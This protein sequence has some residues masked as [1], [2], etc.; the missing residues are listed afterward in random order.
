[1]KPDHAGSPWSPARLEITGGERSA[2]SALADARRWLD[3]VLSYRRN[4]DISPARTRRQHFLASRLTL[5]SNV[6]MGRRAPHQTAITLND[7]QLLTLAAWRFGEAIGTVCVRRDSAAGLLS[8]TRFGP[9][10]EVLRR[11]HRSLAELTR[12][13]MDPLFNSSELYNALIAAAIRFARTYFASDCVILPMSVG[14]LRYMRQRLG[15]QAVGDTG[16]PCG[17]RAATP[18][19]FQDLDQSTVSEL[20]VP[21]AVAHNNR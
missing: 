16:Q 11:N 1:M 10:V 21:A 19:L 13:A 15:F 9:E 17:K 5:H 18:L 2:A 20:I 8:E 12:I 6:W 7:P 14:H 4:F 3:N